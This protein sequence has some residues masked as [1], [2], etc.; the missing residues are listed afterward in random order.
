MKKTKKLIRFDWAMKK[1]L[2]HKAN[3]DILEGFL[4]ELLGEDIKIHKIL[5]SEVNKE[6]EEDKHNRVDMLVENAKG[7][8]IIIEVQNSQEY[9]YFHRILFGA[10]KAVTEYIKEGEPYASV[11]KVISITIAYFDLG[12]GKDYVYHGTTSF[13][14]IH[15]NDTLNLAIRQKELYGK[16]KV[17]DIFPEYWLI[18]VS[19]FKNRVLDRL[20]EWIYFLKN[21]EV[22]EGFSAKGLPEAKEKLDEMKMTSTEREAYQRYLK[23]L[24]DLASEQH[25]KMADAEEWMKQTEAIAEKKVSFEIA[26]KLK[27]MGLSSIDIHRATGLSAVE[28]EKL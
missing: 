6:N 20:D 27:Q 24:R 26:K 2:R 25:T 19:K 5:E 10:S 23:K 16:E 9:D 21:G 4:T 11:K 14:G 13:K 17:H 8:L 1:L 15:K 22:Q 28:I 18:K 3:F 7:E 12:Q